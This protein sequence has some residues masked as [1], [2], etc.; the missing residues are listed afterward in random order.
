MNRYQRRLQ[1]KQSKKQRRQELSV[2][3]VYNNSF[4]MDYC[5]A[6]WEHTCGHYCEWSVPYPPFEVSKIE[7]F[8]HVRSITEGFSLYPCPWCGGETG[9]YTVPDSVQYG[10]IKNIIVE[11]LKEDDNRIGH[12]D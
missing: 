2:D 6:I 11:K 1:Q 8:A 10:R 12:F 5:S 7:L 3:S 4:E 9:A